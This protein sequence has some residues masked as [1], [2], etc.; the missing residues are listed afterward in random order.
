MDMDPFL[1]RKRDSR[2]GGGEFKGG[3]QYLQDL[4][5]GQAEKQYVPNRDPERFER[6]F[7]YREAEKRRVN[8]LAEENEILRQRQTQYRGMAKDVEKYMKSQQMKIDTLNSKLLSFTN[9]SRDNGGTG[10]DSTSDARASKDDV[11]GRSEGSSSDMPREVL[12]SDIHD[13]SGQ[14]D[15]HTDEGRQGDGKGDSRPAAESGVSAD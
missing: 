14:A 2:M 15:K 13:T 12:P 7:Q 9:G 3:I 8:A 11:K 5:R 4:A 6:A 10:S 1:A